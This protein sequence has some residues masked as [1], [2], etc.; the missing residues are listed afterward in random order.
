MISLVK[1]LIH[2]TKVVSCYNDTE[3]LLT[4]YSLD[5]HCTNNIPQA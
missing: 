1:E 2:P 4:F 5:Y 3:L